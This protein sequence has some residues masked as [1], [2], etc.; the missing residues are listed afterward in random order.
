MMPPV[1]PNRGRQALKPGPFA[2]VMALLPVI[3]DDLIR[4]S[5]QPS[6]RARWTNWYCKSWLSRFSS[7][8]HRGLADVDHR[9]AIQMERC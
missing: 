4:A 8:W 3:I 2:L 5:A 6:E 1:Q 9:R 7:T